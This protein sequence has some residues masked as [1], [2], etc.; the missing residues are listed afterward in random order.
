MEASNL[1]L[2][3]ALVHLKWEESLFA[4]KTNGI[5]TGIKAGIVS[6]HTRLLLG[7]LLYQCTSVD[8]RIR[9]IYQTKHTV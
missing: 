8:T 7:S 6:A 1:R 4:N 3:F 2:L 9:S 5:K